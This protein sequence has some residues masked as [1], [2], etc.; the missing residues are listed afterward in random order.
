MKHFICE[1]ILSCVVASPVG[2]P[3]EELTYGTMLYSYYQQDFHQALLDTMVAE[4]QTR[5]G[6]EFARFDL[7]KGSFAFSDGMYDLA[8]TTFDGVDPE[9]LSQLDQ[10]RLAFHLAREYHRR[11]DYVGV[12]QELARVDLKS[13][14][15]GRKRVHPEVEFMRAEA[16]MAAG[17]NDEAEKLLKRLDEDEP[18]LAYGLYN[19][20]IAYREAGDLEGS[21]RAFERLAGFKVRSKGKRPTN[22]E[23]L[24]LIQRAKLALSFVAREQQSTADAAEVL[25]GLPADGRYRD[26]ALASYG[27]LAMDQGDYELAARIWLTLQ[28]QSYWT[29]S[30]AQARLA[31]P[32]SLEQLASREMALLQYREAERSFETRLALLTALSSQA[33]DPAWVKNLLLVF[34]APETDDERMSELVERWRAQLGHT[35]W[36]EWLATEDTHQ[37]LM[38]WRELLA[39]REWLTLLPGELGAFEEV[40]RE[41]R[42]RGAKANALLHDDALLA[43]RDALEETILVQADTLDVLERSGAERS[44]DW[45]RQLASPDELELLEELAAMRE[46]VTAHMTPK[47]QAKWLGKIDRLE[48]R[49]FWQ[50]ADDRSDRTRTLAKQQAENVALLRDLDARVARVANAEAEFIAGV[51]TDFLSLTDRADVLTADVSRALVARE[52]AL[53]GELRRGMA[54]EMKEVQQYL[55]VTRIGIARATDELA[56]DDETVEGE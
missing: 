25:D 11:G 38:E 36:L 26:V 44:L 6:D 37:V 22:E 29:S 30:T 49:L 33:E 34:S 48:G 52:V 19:L 16:A 1:L 3:I 35:D 50:I 5:R 40:A 51:E 20:G 18:L 8:R 46:M 56:L 39:M 42:R 31:F 27:G 14:W 54:R 10:M 9:E 7:A 24:D 2:K 17:R 23:T 47:D 4:A 41:Q 28:E 13:N 12:E 15:L 55:L 21:R 53:A 32:M 45:M 43:K